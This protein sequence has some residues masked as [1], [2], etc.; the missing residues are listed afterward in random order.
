VID[1]P[2]EYANQGLGGRV[3]LINMEGLGVVV[4]AYGECQVR[5]GAQWTEII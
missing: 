5:N 1:S 3:S 4:A 2:R